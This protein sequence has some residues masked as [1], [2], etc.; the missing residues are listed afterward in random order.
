[1][2]ARREWAA[3][4]AAT[5]VV[6]TGAIAGATATDDTG[7]ILAFVGALVVALITAYTTE[8]RQREQLAHDRRLQ[9]LADFRDLLK[10][11]S[12]LMHSHS[13]PLVQLLAATKNERGEVAGEA[14]AEA[15]RAVSTLVESQPVL[16]DHLGELLLYFEAEDPIFVAFTRYVG[17]L[18][19]AVDAFLEN[20]PAEELA[21]RVESEIGVTGAS[22]NEL[23]RAAR[24]AVGYRD[25][26]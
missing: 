18:S 7:P 11:T 25:E 3:I 10:R 5:T 20:M 13:A 24:D 1:V 2:S 22:A 9:D 14:L 15:Q 8:R 4:A 12:V 19:R 26:P 6:A 17:A 23:R 16:A 21:A